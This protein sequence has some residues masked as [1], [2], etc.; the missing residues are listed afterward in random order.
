PR[1]LRDGAHH[2]D[3]TNREDEVDVRTAFDQRAQLV[4]DE[5]FLCVAAIIGG[6]L[7]LVTDPAH[8]GFKDHEFFGAGADDGDDTIADSLERCSCGVGHSRAHAATYNNH[9]SEFLD[10]G[11][12]AERANDVAYAVASFERVQK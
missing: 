5:T 9:A 8:F 2:G 7:D 10:L 6:D 11:G 4:G 3:G 1:N 12:I